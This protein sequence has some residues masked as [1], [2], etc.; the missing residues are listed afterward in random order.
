MKRWISMW[1]IQVVCI[2]FASFHE[3]ACAY[4]PIVQVHRGFVVM[5]FPI[6]HIWLN[7]L[8]FYQDVPLLI[9][10]YILWNEALSAAKLW[11]SFTPQAKSCSTRESSPL[12]ASRTQHSLSA[13]LLFS[14]YVLYFETIRY[15]QEATAQWGS[16]NNR[17]GCAVSLQTV[18]DGRAQ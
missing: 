10:I 11:M 13:R 9:H 1:L 14:L 16:T 6:V 5:K 3:I 17:M 12:V 8:I 7:H 4:Q 18:L 2:G 15:P